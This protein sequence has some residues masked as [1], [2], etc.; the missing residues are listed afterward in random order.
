M[1]LSANYSKLF[2]KHLLF[3]N[4]QWS[5]SQ[6]K[7]EMVYFQAQGFANN[8]MDYITNAKEYV[9]GS[10]Y[11]DE[12]VVRETSVLASVN[13]SYDDRYLLDATYRANASS[14]FGADKRW[15]SFWST[16]IGWNIHKERFFEG[17]SF[18]EKLS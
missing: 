8:K 9:S 12:S 11:G 16:G 18:L 3:A 13:Y 4:A 7:S 6:K 14:L 2:G 17:V 10:P 5:I 1:D 15:G